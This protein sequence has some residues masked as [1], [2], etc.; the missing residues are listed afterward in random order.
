MNYKIL[1]IPYKET[2]PWIK[3]KHYAK[4][5]PNI[6]YSFGCYN[7]NNILQGV[8]CFGTPANNHNN[9]LGTFTMIEL[10]RLVLNDGHEKNLASF[11]ISK[12]LKQLPPP[13]SNNQLCRLWIRASWL[14]ISSNKLDIYG[15]RWWC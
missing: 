11:F 12:S 14:Y 2:Y 9:M 10:V 1:P 6:T 4:S 15:S 13:N 5:I 8:C 7:E 3:N